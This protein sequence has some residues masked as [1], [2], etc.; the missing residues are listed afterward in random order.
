MSPKEDITTTKVELENEDFLLVFI[1]E[2]MELNLFGV[3]NDHMYLLM[4][5]S[6]M[7]PYYLRFFLQTLIQ[8]CKVLCEQPYR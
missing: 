4:Q 5:K 6:K 7:L 1:T 2:D 8:L 3:I